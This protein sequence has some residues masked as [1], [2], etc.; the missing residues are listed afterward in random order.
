MRLILT[1][2]LFL[3]SSAYAVAETRVALVMVLSV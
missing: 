2:L 1:S 3:W